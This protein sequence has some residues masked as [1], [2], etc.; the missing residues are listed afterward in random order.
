M[1][2]EVSR[3]SLLSLIQARS[4]DLPSS[5]RAV[6]SSDIESLGLRDYQSLVDLL[7][8]LKQ[9]GLIRLG[10]GTK[11]KGVVHWPARITPD[12]IEHLEDS[13]HRAR[14][15]RSAFVAMWFAPE[16]KD[17]WTSGL[18]P[19]LKDVGFE[20]VRIDELHHNGKICD[21][22]LACIRDSSL[23]V[24]DFTG[25]R[26]GVYFESGFALGLSIPVIW[27]CRRDWI[28]KIHFDTRQYNHIVWDTAEEL[29]ERLRDRAL[30]TIGRPAWTVPSS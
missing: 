17:A 18:S 28:D 15:S 24:A 9:K 21:A 25:N 29:R 5:G 20:P 14:R 10:K 22:I 19:G 26:G 2:I 11:L 23:V 3:T 7:L 30:A 8:D 12:G 6:S 13:R 4:I 1:S 16:T 27:S